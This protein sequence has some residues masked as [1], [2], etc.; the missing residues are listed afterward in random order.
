MANSRS[1]RSRADMSARAWLL[2]LAICCSGNTLAGDTLARAS[3][4][5]LAIIIDDI[6]YNKN[7]SD[8][9]ARLPGAFTLSVLP[10]TP[11]GLSAAQLAH[12]NHKELMLHAPMSN[13]KDL[14]LGRGGLSSTMSKEA[15]IAMLRQDLDNLPYIKGVNNHMG[16]R[17]TQEPEPMGWV[18]AELKSRGLYFIDSRT[19]AL[20]VALDTAQAH[21]IPSRKRD[22]FLDDNPSSAAISYQ[23]ERAF[24]LAKRQGSAIAIGHPYPTTLSILEKI[25]PLLQQQAI[26]LVF[27]SQLFARSEWPLEIAAGANTLSS[28]Q[29]CGAPPPGLWF[30]PRIGIRLADIT[31]AI[32]LE[33]LAIHRSP[34][35]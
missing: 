11:H 9:A 21:Q 2:A 23:L 12:A 8:R 24:A 1:R 29:S 19:S 14:P 34:N 5:R 30:R 4:G 31:D 26:R 25:Q 22:V 28:V 16:S 6:G 18:M 33:V 13:T 15:F 7:L 32:L 20:T 10:F 3:Q 27:V 17:L 35:H